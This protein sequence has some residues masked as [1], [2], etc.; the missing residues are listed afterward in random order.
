MTKKL[1]FV[2]RKLISFNLFARSIS[3]FTVSG[4]CYETQYESITYKQILAK[5]F[6]Q[7]HED[8]FTIYHTRS[9]H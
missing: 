3:R 9:D 8:K 1:L 5:E 4:K 6:S 2:Y 7:K